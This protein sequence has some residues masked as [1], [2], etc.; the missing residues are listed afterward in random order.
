M[1]IDRSISFLLSQILL[2]KSL[3]QYC[4]K[5]LVTFYKNIAGRNDSSLSHSDLFGILKDLG[6]VPIA[7]NGAGADYVSGFF[8]TPVLLLSKDGDTGIFLEPNKLHNQ[9][10]SLLRL[11]NYTSYTLFARLPL[12]PI[13][14]F[15]FAW[16]Q[17]LPQCQNY[18]ATLLFLMMAAIISVIPIVAIDPIFNILVPRGDINRI[19]IIGV[20]LVA[21]QIIGSL[22]TAVSSLFSTLIEQDISY[23]SY[24][25][26]IDRFLLA[27]PLGLPKR[28][29]GTW[30][31]TFKTALAFTSSIRAI[32]I[33]MPLAIFTIVL[34]CIVFGLALSRPWVVIFLIFLCSIPAVVNVLFGLRVGR[35][36][37]GL[38]SVNSRVDQHLFTSFRTIGDARSLGMATSLSRHFASLREELNTITLSMNSW[39]QAGIF[40]NSLLG[41]LLVAVILFLYTSSSGISQGSYL[42]IFVAFSSVSNGFTQLAASVSQILASAPTYLS[43]NSIR[44][45]RDFSPYRIFTSK[46]AES[47]RS[48]S[49]HLTI[50]L[51]QLSFNYDSKEP[52]L[53]NFSTTFIYN[54][55]YAI[56]GAPGSGKSTLIKII[57][58]VYS[59][60]EGSV[61]I[62]GI[63]SS[64]K[65]NEL[66]QYSVMYIPQVGKLLGATLRDFIDPFGIKSDL[67]I[68]DA[69][70]EV[71]LSDLLETMHMGLRSVV[72][73]LS[74]DLSSGQVQLLQVAR[75]YLHKPVLL[76]SDEPTAF[77]PED[78]HLR[79]LSLLNSS[80]NLHISTLHRLSGKDL[81]THIIPLDN[82]GTR[83]V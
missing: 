43:K 78:Q 16:F 13:S 69:I 55:T 10:L 39:S 41:S 19:I 57:G 11:D 17:F 65:V 34:N 56:T 51:R 18:L 52:L 4:P 60:T 46:T 20:A 61:L 79:I 12:V 76:L 72:S 36:G 81:F 26:I 5:D 22:S 48:A 68:Q 9:T 53:R 62:N 67:Q 49:C 23:R 40:L 42:V 6:I 82:S 2:T 38:V 70:A 73:E 25:S 27:Q 47:L 59:P 21:S 1:I 31:Q 63:P 66:N 28:E 54:N 32:A 83:P 24:M 44:D 29:A 80:C 14:K 3:I 35:I 58:G 75:A 33:T 50:E 30:S 71:G 77:L 45:I 15:K 37:Y 8:R 7:N 74:T 64:P